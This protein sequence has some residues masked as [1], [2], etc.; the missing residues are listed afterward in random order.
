M[1]LTV[2]AVGRLKE[3]YWR[4]AADEYL[5]RLGSY[6]TVRVVEVDDRDSGRD[7]ARALA[8]EGADVLRAL[9]DGAHV[10]ALE[11]GGVP[12]SSERFASRLAALALD[13][14]SARRI[15]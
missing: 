8:D 10:I 7:V 4:E 15:D 11:I 2:V 5:K 13:G 12:L 6:A 14:R 3:R 9:P 1:R